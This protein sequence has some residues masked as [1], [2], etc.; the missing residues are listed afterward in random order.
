[1]TPSAR[2]FLLVLVAFLGAR[3]TFSSTCA[4]F[5]LLPVLALLLSALGLFVAAPAQATTPTVSLSATPNPAR[6]GET[7]VLRVTLS[8]ALSHDVTIPVHRVFLPVGDQ[9]GHVSEITIPAGET[10]GALPIKLFSANDST[11]RLAV[12]LAIPPPPGVSYGGTIPNLVV[13]ANPPPPPPPDPPSG[14]FPPAVPSDPAPDS[15]PCG[16]SDREDLERFYE[17]TDGEDWHENENWNSREPLNQ[18]YGVET[19]G[20]GEVISLRLSENNLSGDIPTEELLCLTE[21]K[22]L[23]LWGNDRLSGDV[24]EELVPAVERAVLRDIA[25]MLNLNPEW[26]ENYEDPFNFED[27]YTGV[28]TDDERRVIEL[29]FTGEEITGEIPE[30]VFELQRLEEISTGCGITLE[31]EA[32]E[33]V[34]V[35]VPDDCEAE[36]SGDGGCALG[37]GDSSAFALFLVTLFVFAVLGRT[38]ARG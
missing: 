37:S 27:W 36:A 15:T 23:A 6:L 5:S 34:S 10:S 21:L 20:A 32:P 4:R 2:C 30:S 17:M 24:P 8:S 35:M 14:G 11:V 18:W 38:R 29:D 26:F 3:K 1:M 12:T 31:V 7:V 13:T 22:E 28:T 9:L 19:N 33:T 16:E 25:E